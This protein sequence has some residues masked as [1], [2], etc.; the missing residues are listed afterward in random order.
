MNAPLSICDDVPGAVRKLTLVAK[1]LQTVFG[2]QWRVRFEKFGRH[3]R[4][5]I[6][7]VFRQQMYLHAAALQPGLAAADQQDGDPAAALVHRHPLHLDDQMD[8]A[9]GL[10]L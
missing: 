3:R 6:T 1:L 7:V 4:L 2:T 5:L 8:L 9:A 10:N